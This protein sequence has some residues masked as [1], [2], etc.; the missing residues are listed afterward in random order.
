[1]LQNKKDPRFGGSFDPQTTPPTNPD[2]ESTPLAPSKVEHRLSS[3][4]YTAPHGSG[5]AKVI[6]N[7]STN[8]SHHSRLQNFLR[9]IW[10]HYNNVPKLYTLHL[11]IDS[12]GATRARLPTKRFVT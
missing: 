2:H 3:G 10:L 11:A 1:M 8:P 5:A 7:T 6:A 4:I 9:K 12:Q